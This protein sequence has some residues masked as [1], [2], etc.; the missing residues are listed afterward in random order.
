M[1]LYE[2][3]DAKLN[4]MF[5][6]NGDMY[7]SLLCNLPAVYSVWL[8]DI[9]NLQTIA[10]ESPDK[11]LWTAHKEHALMFLYHLARE[12]WQQEGP[13]FDKKSEN[14]WEKPLFI[15]FM[16]QNGTRNYF[17]CIPPAPFV[18]QQSRSSDPSNNSSGRVDQKYVEDLD[19]HIFCN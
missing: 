17:K 9:D 5:L 16:R 3:L 4:R 11:F 7:K 13:H 18:W 14:T 6:G 10:L 2:L 8:D 15:T 19:V 12:K 1:E